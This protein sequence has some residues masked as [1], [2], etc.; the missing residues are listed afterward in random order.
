MQVNLLRV[1]QENEVTRVGET[2]PRTINVRVIAATN[3]DLE[4]EVQ[5]ARFREDLFYRLGVFPSSCRR[6]GTVAEMSHFLAK[7]FLEMHT[8]AFGQECPGFTK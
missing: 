3:K 4:A 6:S 8:A 5:E 7:H 2:E 1:L